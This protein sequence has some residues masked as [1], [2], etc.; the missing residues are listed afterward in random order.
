MRNRFRQ[1]LQSL[2]PP[3]RRI[4]PPAPASNRRAALAP[5]QVLP[6]IT[7]SK[8]VSIPGDEGWGLHHRRRRL[9]GRG[10]TFL[11]APH[12]RSS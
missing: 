3:L 6:V 8:T 1:H 7:S 12:V 10:P 4:S 2:G 9:H 11:M 5:L